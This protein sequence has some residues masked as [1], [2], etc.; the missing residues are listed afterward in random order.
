[1]G[2][3]SAL[4]SASPLE[5]F[6]RA[7][8][9]INYGL[10]SLIF[11]LN[12]LAVPGLKW[13]SLLYA[14]FVLVAVLALDF[15]Q[16]LTLIIGYSFLEGQ[17]RVLWEYNPFFRIAFDLTV[18][19]A[20]VRN[21][22]VQRDLST[23]GVLPR[24]VLL[25]LL[26]HFMWYLVEMFNPAL[27]SW[28]LPVAA[29]KAYIF[30][31]LLFLLLRK[32]PQA[33]EPQWLRS[34]SVFILFLLGL[35]IALCLYQFQFKQD[36]MLALS[37]YYAKQMKQGVFTDFFFRP[38]GTTHVPGAI[39]TF[40]YLATGFLFFSDHFSKKRISMILGVCGLIV[41]TILICQVRSALVKFLLLTPASAFAVMV[42][43]R[44]RTKVMLRA[45]LVSVL[46]GSVG[47]G[48]VVKNIDRISEIFDLEAGLKRWETVDSYDSFKARRLGP[49]DAF[50]AAQ[51]RLGQ[52]PL[53]LGP[54]TTAAA[55]ILSGDVK[56]SDPV[57]RQDL[58]WGFDNL[59][60]SVIVEFGYGAVIYIALL[61]SMPWLLFRKFR[62]LYRTGHL[63]ES[64]FVLIAFLHVFVI[65]VGNWGM[66]GIPYNP[67]SFFFWLWTATGL[68][69]YDNT[70]KKSVSEDDLSA[71]A[72]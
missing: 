42:T 41:V 71:A 43:T 49:L 48:Y 29:T 54:G 37:P 24:P 22:V 23:K 34:I 19:V 11:L 5:R 63:E 45:L 33:F 72:T 18:G 17:S 20:I 56:K 61:A 2:L 58:F 35:E 21:F 12:F 44:N 27:V 55:L 28:F 64:R 68:N 60:L 31:F 15:K 46:L 40:L 62:T 69:V 70:M 25:L 6:S 39:T 38:F 9:G 59:Y 51:L 7:V 16:T 52:F 36:F 26:L 32:N 50:N 66:I 10:I 65:L 67:E 8:V 3:S 1:M 30:P 57:Y 47:I 13:V 4:P 53:G 14:V